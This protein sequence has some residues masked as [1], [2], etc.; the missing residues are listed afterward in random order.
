ML[1]VFSQNISINTDASLPNANAILDIKSG[2]KGLLIPRMS[3]KARNTIPN[4]RGLLVYDT[5]TNS[6]WYNTGAQWQAIS[7]GA[8]SL[9]V[10]DSAW[11]IKGNSNVHDTVNFLGTINNV[12]L[13]IRVNNQRSGRIDPTRADTYWGYRA[14]FADTGNNNTA[15]GYL[16]LQ[17]NISGNF[18]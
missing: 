17:S 4:T 1:P 7:S 10:A 8:S 13:N 6:F 5:T 3:T 14:G 12:P 9:S 16:A 18:N 11:L 15:N 2:N